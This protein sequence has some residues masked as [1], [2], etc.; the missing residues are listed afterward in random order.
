MEKLF[1]NFH[2]LESYAPKG[3]EEQHLYQICK[4]F[5]SFTVVIDNLIAHTNVQSFF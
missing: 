4:L 5:F 1:L 3:M 2:F